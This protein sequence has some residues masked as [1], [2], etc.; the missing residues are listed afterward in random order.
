MRESP[1]SF[2]PNCGSNK[3]FFEKDFIEDDSKKYITTTNNTFD[4]LLTSFLLK[5]YKNRKH[6]TIGHCSSCGHSW[7]ILED[8]TNFFEVF[9][10]IILIVFSIGFV[11]IWKILEWYFNTDKIPISSKKRLYLLFGIIL[12]VSMIFGLIGAIN[13]PY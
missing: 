6:R 10:W 9:I 2:C 8:K 7:Q 3:V 1:Y 12:F 4:H 13:N 11:L 5:N